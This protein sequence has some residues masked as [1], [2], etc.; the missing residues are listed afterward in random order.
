VDVTLYEGLPITTVS[1]TVT[2]ILT[3][4]GRAD[5]ARQAIADARKEGHI[6]KL[7]AIRLKRRVERFMRKSSPTA[8]QKSKEHP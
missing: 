4:S 5:T 7:E 2:D 1:R 3:T 8:P 6:S